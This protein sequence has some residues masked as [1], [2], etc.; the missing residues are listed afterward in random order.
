MRI[1]LFNYPNHDSTVF[2]ARVES[3][4]NKPTFKDAWKSHRCIIPASYYFEWEHF[5]SPDGK[6]KIGDKYA[7]NDMIAEKVIEE[8]P[9][10]T[11]I[12]NQMTI[13]YVT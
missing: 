3:A 12:P 9:D 5:K 13:K 10:K 1:G 6:T 8:K 7:I 4:K 2:N 11:Q